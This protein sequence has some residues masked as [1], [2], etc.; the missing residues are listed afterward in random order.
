MR[1]PHRLRAVVLSGHVEPG[2][3]VVV[4]GAGGVG[5]S[6]IQL[7]RSIGAGEVILVDVI[8]WKLEKGKEMGATVILN[9][10]KINVKDYVASKGGVDVVVECAGRPET[11]ELALELVRVGGRVVLVGIPPANSS[12]SVRPASLVRRGVTILT[13]HGGRPRTDLPRL[14]EMSRTG[15][16]SPEA[17]I[18]GEY[19][20][21]EI[22]E[23]VSAL[24]EGRVLRT[25]IVP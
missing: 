2:E 5:L 8:D 10:L 4:I 19:R 7:L 21:E 24:L 25:L 3:N 20:L 18:T 16:Y 1:W 11:V 22:N 23:A 12:V 6:I 13:N 17:L 14:I 9:S 15:K